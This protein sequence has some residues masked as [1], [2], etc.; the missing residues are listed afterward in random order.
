MPVR[1]HRGRMAEPDENSGIRCRLFCFPYAGAGAAV[2]RQWPDDLPGD[3]ELCIPCLPGRDARVDEPPA[4][5]MAPL[6]D[7]IAEEIR[8]LLGVP[9]AV[10]GHSMGAFVAF[11]LAHKLSDSGFAPARVFVAAQRGPRRPYPAKPIFALPDDA[12]LAA[13]LDRYHSIPEPILRQQDLMSVLLR[14]LRGDF[15]LVEDYH[16]RAA[17]LL[18]CPVTA[19]GGR[20]DRQIDREQLAAWSCETSCAF[21]L[22]LLPGGHFFL[23]ESRKPL[24]AIIRRQLA[25]LVAAG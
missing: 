19:F 6:V 3:I 17:R 18:S 1:R 4:T 22:H 14:T 11:D 21:D 7:G 12:F 2:F 16:Y 13:L 5:A 10:F 23:Q 15:T 9:Y 25:T 20:E 24:L 8:P